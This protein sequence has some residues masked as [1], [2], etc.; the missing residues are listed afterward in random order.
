M[1]GD[2]FRGGDSKR[3]RLRIS[4]PI[5][6]R[7]T[8]PGP[9]RVGC[10]G[11]WGKA[12]LT[13]GVAVGG[14]GAIPASVSAGYGPGLRREDRIHS[15]GYPEAPPLQLCSHFGRN[16]GRSPAFSCGSPQ[17]QMKGPTASGQ[18]LRPRPVSPQD[19]RRGG[20]DS[21]LPTALEIWLRGFG[22]RDLRSVPLAPAAVSCSRRCSSATTGPDN[23]HSGGRRATSATAHT[24]PRACPS[25]GPET[26]IPSYP[27]VPAL[28]RCPAS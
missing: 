18:S 19:G 7:F 11:R 5:I 4:I 3:S 23:G 12:R 17:G 9:R 28:Q 25:A 26:T 2:F 20:E 14:L 1:R 16:V 22:I 27:R 13:W 8:L 21:L 24:D 6:V 15:P 10:S